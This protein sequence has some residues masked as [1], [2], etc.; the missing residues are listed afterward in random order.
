MIQLKTWEFTRI[1]DYWWLGGNIVN[2]N[3]IVY[4]SQANDVITGGVED[5]LE[6]TLSGHDFMTG[7]GGLD[8]IVIKGLAKDASFSLVGK[9]GMESD[10]A[11]LVFLDDENTV[12]GNIWG[13]HL[14]GDGEHIILSH[15]SDRPGEFSDSLYQ[16]NLTTGEVKPI[17]VD[18]NGNKGT[19]DSYQALDMS[20]DGRYVLFTL[21]AYG[22]VNLDPNAPAGTTSKL[23]LFSESNMITG[24][25]DPR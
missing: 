25:I 19:G 20:A 9:F 5:Q 7:G 2:P 13:G 3:E 10:D 22:D 18:I 23:D 1:G 6:H 14:S 15:H 17:P 4:G 11:S 21:D 16:K 8:T 24:E 12:S